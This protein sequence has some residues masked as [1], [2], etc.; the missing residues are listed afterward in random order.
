M[1]EANPGVLSFFIFRGWQL[2]A[3]P[4]TTLL[5]TICL[6]PEAQGFW[7]TM[8][9]LLVFQIVAD[10]GFNAVLIQF[11]SHE[12][13]HLRLHAGEVHGDDAAR[14]RL[15]SIIRI[16]FI[17]MSLASIL[18]FVGIG[19]VGYLFFELS[20]TTDSVSWQGPWSLLIVGLVITMQSA[21]LRAVSEGRQRLEQGQHAQL[22]ATVVAYPTCWAML[23]TGFGL[24]SLA[25]QYI[26]QGTVS[27]VLLSIRNRH[28]LLLAWQPSGED[29][30]PFLGAFWRQQWRIGFSWLSGLAMYQAMTPIVFYFQGPT[31]AGQ[32]GLLFQ[33][34][35]FI[36]GLSTAWVT[37]AQPHFGALWAQSRFA[38]VK[39]LVE[40]TI[41]K[42]QITTLIAVGLVLTI[43]AAIRIGL[44]QYGQRFPG[45]V[46]SALLLSV[47][48]FLQRMN[49]ET[50]AIR[51][52]KREPFVKAAALTS[53]TT[54]GALLATAHL[55]TTALILVFG[56]MTA[57]VLSQWCHRIYIDEMRS[58]TNPQN[59]PRALT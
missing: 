32:F 44:P 31:V 19:G 59:E 6:S 57:G 29:R 28:V 3:L 17:W 53:L 39:A 33:V 38:E 47:C 23:M 21:V 22:I 9:S 40:T 56:L 11:I 51:F 1:F 55:S 27:V 12:W 48:V 58:L 41:R 49:V 45:L 8:M 24:Y 50:A 34:Y 25:A 43:I 42:S 13:A 2:V 35:M 52:A 16:A 5:V 18:A 14:R 37:Q 26:I 20:Q 36:F 54:L 7:F 30:V 10:F 15:A 4:I 46:D